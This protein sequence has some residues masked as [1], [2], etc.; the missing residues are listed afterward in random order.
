MKAI[1]IYKPELDL[2][3]VAADGSPAAY[4]LGWYDRQSNSM[5]FEPVGTSPEHAR[6][7]LSQA[8]CTAV[9]RAAR[10][11]GA[12]QAVVGPRGDNAYPVPQRL[13]QSLGFTTLA[14]TCS[15]TWDAN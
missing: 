1:D 5:L 4:A 14:R 9:M 3:I 15:L 2:V 10:D 12:T 7:G 6:R 13:Y 8:V 11:L